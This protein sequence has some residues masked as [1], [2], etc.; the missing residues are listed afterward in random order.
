MRWGVV[1]LVSALA[2]PAPSA[3][4]SAV[5]T[6]PRAGHP[7]TLQVGLADLAYD[8]TVADRLSIGGLASFT[9]DEVAASARATGT[10]WSNGDA[11]ALGWTT[12]LGASQTTGLGARVPY[13]V[14]VPHEASLWV[15]PALAVAVP[16]VFGSRI[17]FIGGPSFGVA[18]ALIYPEAR[19]LWTAS[20]PYGWAVIRY[21]GTSELAFP[22][23]DRHEVTF[24]GS[25]I[26]GWRRRL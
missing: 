20:T 17:R 23:G 1:V 9:F 12:S 5:P 7:N 21:V 4:A 16:F 24:G 3:Y 13:G 8:R 19:Y 22:I 6:L 10:I 2:A 25:A 14:E 11:L 26:V 18:D 15:R